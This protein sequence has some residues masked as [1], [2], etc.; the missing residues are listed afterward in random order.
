MQ[1]YGDFD[2]SISPTYLEDHPLTVGT[3]EVNAL[4][5]SK[6]SKKPG[7]DGNNKKRKEQE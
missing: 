2:G 5:P 6:R 3:F 1:I 7:E 4:K